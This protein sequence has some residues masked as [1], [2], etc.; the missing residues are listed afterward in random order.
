MFSPCPGIFRKVLRPIL[1]AV[2]E[3]V[4]SAGRWYSP[5][6]YSP[7]TTQGPPVGFAGQT[8]G[9][10]D[11]KQRGRN[12]HSQPANGDPRA[13]FAIHCSHQR[14]PTRLVLVIHGINGME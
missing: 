7:K 10:W 4:Y 12:R 5:P 2:V 14:N 1:C 8:R 6:G 3:S 9:H 11:S 13:D